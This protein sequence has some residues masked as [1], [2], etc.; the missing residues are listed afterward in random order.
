MSLV[1]HSHSSGCLQVKLQGLHWKKVS[2]L[3]F[4]LTME[5]RGVNSAL[6]E[7]GMVEQRRLG[8]TLLNC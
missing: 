8:D 3:L 4:C 5:N 7:K 6:A 2:A 1:Q